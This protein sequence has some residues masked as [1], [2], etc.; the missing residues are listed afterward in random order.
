MQSRTLGRSGIAIPPLMFG[1]NVFGWTADKAQS[2]RLLDAAVDAGFTAID[3]ADV[4]SAWVDGNKGGESETIMGEWLAERKCRDKVVIATKVGMAMGDGR[5][6]LSR[7]WILHEID[8]SLTRLQTDYV[9]LY[10][11]HKDD[12]TVPLEETLQ[13]FAELI[14]A[15]KVRAIGASNYKGARLKEALDVS[16]KHGLPRY[17]TLQPL[18]NL[19]ERKDYEADLAPVVQEA[20]LSVIPYFALASGFLTGKYRAKADLASSLRGSRVEKY[21]NE[22]GAKVIA[23][24][25]HVAERHGSNPTQIAIAWLIAQPNIAAPI[26]SASKPEQM[27]DLVKACD[28]KLSANDVAVLDAATL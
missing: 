9:D 13:T 24:L 16:A 18:Y 11:A 10:Q 22:G 27:A 4:Y 8:A 25:D 15:G 12:E 19:L 21:L 5:K 6:G 28:V 17:E 20:G 23:A 2:F 3:T 7:E 14:K 1:G 26:A